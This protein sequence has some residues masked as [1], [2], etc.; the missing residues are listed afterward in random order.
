MIELEARLF[1]HDAVVISTVGFLKETLQQENCEAASKV[2]RP[3]T[4][5]TLV[6][7]DMDSFMTTNGCLTHEAQSAPPQPRAACK[8]AEASYVVARWCRSTP[9]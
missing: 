5:I 2:L 3:S 1:I 4:E 6:E 8:V 9:S 7:V